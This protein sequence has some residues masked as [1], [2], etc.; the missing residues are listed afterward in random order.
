MK[1]V[2]VFIWLFF[3]VTLCAQVYNLEN[4][5]NPMTTNSTFVSNPDG[6]LKSETVAQINS[7]LAALKTSNTSE[8]VVVVV[9]SIGDEDIKSFATQLLNKWGV[10]SKQ[11]NNGLLILFV[12]D[13]RQITIEVGYGLEGVLPD[14]ICKRIQNNDMIPSFK[15][16]N[17][18]EGFISGVNSIVS[19][20]KG[21]TFVEKQQNIP[22]AEILPVALGIYLLLILISIVWISG[23]VNKIRKNPR[24]SSNLTRFKAI[25]TE[26][27]AGLLIMAFV[28]PAIALVAMILFKAPVYLIVLLFPVPF[29]ALPAHI[30]GRILMVKVRREPVKCTE[31]GDMMHILSEKQ[32]D[33]YLKLSQQF[34]EQL[35]AV[36]YDVFVCDS[37]KNET[38]YTY[39]KP[40]IYSN[41]PKCNTKAFI[42]K[43]KRTMIAPTYVSSGTERVTYHCK[44]CGYE[45]NHNNNLP[46]LTGNAGSIAKGAAIGSILSSGRGGFGGGGFGGGS[47]GGGMS[48]GGGATSGW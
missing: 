43:E 40:S 2:A 13:Q 9:N 30:Y 3:S 31:C 10:G 42:L 6:I 19:R 33:A 21:E 41:C 22:W 7:T 48:G 20:V 44:F 27:A 5:P 8:V 28:L 25:K 37:C 29:T 18:D 1:A 36:D 39:D 11:N 47:F 35:H 46:R 45:E 23:I 24:Y 15:N 12:S 14:A 16:G 34:E 4:V 32:E 26:K 38:I 17:F